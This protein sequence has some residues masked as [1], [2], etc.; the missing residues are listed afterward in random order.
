MRS[1]N[2]MGKNSLAA[3]RG[4]LF[5]VHHRTRQKHEGDPL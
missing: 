3:E 4:G 5:T 2:V 1:D